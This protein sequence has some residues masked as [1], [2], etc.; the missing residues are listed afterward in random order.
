MG[1]RDWI[2]ALEY[3]RLNVQNILHLNPLIALHDNNC[4]LFILANKN[5]LM[6][7]NFNQYELKSEYERQERLLK[8]FFK[9]KLGL[10]SED[11]ENW[12]TP[13]EFEQEP[14]EIL[15]SIQLPFQCDQFV[16]VQNTDYIIIWSKLQIALIECL[17]NN[18]FK[19]IKYTRLGVK[20]P[21]I[22][23]MSYKNKS[24]LLVHSVQ[25]IL[26]MPTDKFIQGIL[27][28]ELKTYLERYSARVYSTNLIMDL[29]LMGFDSKKQQIIIETNSR[30]LTWIDIY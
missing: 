22:K 17:D 10:K 4:E 7:T 6:K 5:I 15:S 3:K 28:A 14:F 2:Q 29:P 18:K 9:D 24:C 8:T 26:T 1:T 13:N 19:I 30:E 20:L 27:R 21:I 16:L 12:L 25:H 11:S 23:N